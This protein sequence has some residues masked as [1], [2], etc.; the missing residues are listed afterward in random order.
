MPPRGEGLSRSVCGARAAHVHV[1]IPTQAAEKAPVIPVKTGMT[2]R[3]RGT[4]EASQPAAFTFKRHA[5]SNGS[6]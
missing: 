5:C 3:L 2:G 6:V 1:V 4:D